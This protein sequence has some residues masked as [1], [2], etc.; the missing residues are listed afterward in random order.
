[1]LGALMMSGATPVV[2]LPC[3]AVRRAEG[4]VPEWLD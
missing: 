4:A 1:L 2:I 3:I